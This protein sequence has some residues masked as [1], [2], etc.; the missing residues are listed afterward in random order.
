MLSIEMQRT[1][2]DLSFPM[3][4]DRGGAEKTL[5]SA[6][7]CPSRFLQPGML[8]LLLLFLLGLGQSSCLNAVVS[9]EYLGST[10]KHLF[11]FVH[12]SIALIESIDHITR[13]LC[14]GHRHSLHSFRPSGSNRSIR[15]ILQSDHQIVD[16]ATSH[17]R[18][19]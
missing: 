17:C 16:Q 12:V 9:D 19:R 13:L 15:T 14:L 8:F 1:L 2:R 11:H 6:R 4:G 10:G 18:L 7:S 3:N 5:V